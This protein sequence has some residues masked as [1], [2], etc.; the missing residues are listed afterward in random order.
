MNM[1]VIHADVLGHRA[2]AARPAWRGRLH[3]WAFVA[4]IPAGAAIVVAADHTVDRTAAAIYAATLIALFGT[5]AS[6]HR[7]ARSQRARRIMQR[8]D[9]SMIYLLI[10]GTYTPV[11]L[12]A[13]PRVW[14]VPIL[15][16]IGAAAAAGIV[17]KVVAF[18]R[19]QRFTYAL[20]PIMGWTVIVVA[21]ALVDHLT[22]TQ[23]G[24][25]AAGG[26]AYT[27]GVIVLLLHRPDPMPTIFGYHEVWH[28]LTIVAAGLHYVAITDIVG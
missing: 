22:V 17:L 14:G 26:I 23:V 21:P 16:T 11:C 1:V 2:I 12:V 3:T 15:G 18:D 6:Y 7:L 9:H 10:A 19:A 25:I 8:L 28:A 24:L 13:L 5:S 27:V 20:Y 4:A